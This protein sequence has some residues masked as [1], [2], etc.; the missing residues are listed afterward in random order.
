MTEVLI[1]VVEQSYL[2]GINTDS[3]TGRKALLL[4][5]TVQLSVS[6]FLVFCR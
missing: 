6:T 3:A 5:S 1:L 2:L 4:R